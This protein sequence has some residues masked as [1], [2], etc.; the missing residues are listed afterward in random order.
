MPHFW[1]NFLSSKFQEL[2][3]FHPGNSVFSLPFGAESNGAEEE[4]AS[5]LVFN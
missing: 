1:H 4:E 5:W 3:G 2:I